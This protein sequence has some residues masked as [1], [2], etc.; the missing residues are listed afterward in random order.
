MS[1]SLPTL[2]NDETYQLWGIVGNQPVSLGLL[3]RSPNQSMF[4]LV[5]DPS[6]AVQLGVSVEPTGGSVVPTTPMLESGSA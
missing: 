1:S 4:T 5:G 2:E 3:G 6:S